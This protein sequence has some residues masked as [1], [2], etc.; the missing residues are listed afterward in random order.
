MSQ[1]QDNSGLQTVTQRVL[2]AIELRDGWEVS[3]DGEG[4]FSSLELDYRAVPLARLNR[5]SWPGLD[6][7]ASGI[8]V[9]VM[10]HDRIAPGFDR[11]HQG[12][13]AR[14]K[15]IDCQHFDDAV[16]AVEHAMKRVEESVGEE[17][18]DGHQKTRLMTDG[19]RTQS[20]N[21]SK[22]GDRVVWTEGNDLPEIPWC[23][24]CWERIPHED[25]P[26][27]HCGGENCGLI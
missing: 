20:R 23:F 27:T 19:G 5:S 6:V 24:D 3:A 16:A 11:N 26:C 21:A 17:L 18:R 9:T 15:C 7:S 12:I 13:L 2:D 8:V 10:S 4:P 22:Y 25:E 1:N 14:G